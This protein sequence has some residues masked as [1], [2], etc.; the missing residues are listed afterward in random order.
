MGSGGDVIYRFFYFK[1]FR[2]FCLAERNDFSHFGSG[3]PKKHSCGIQR[4]GTILGIYVE[5][6]PRYIS[7][8][9]FL[10][11]VTGLGG[12]VI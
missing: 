12:D 9:F 3:S 6:H 7:V 8:I 4:R 1:I 5:G 2:P 10:N 11:Q